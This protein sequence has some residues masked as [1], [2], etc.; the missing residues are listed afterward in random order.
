[1]FCDDGQGSRDFE[2]Q[3]RVFHTKYR[4]HH[5][6]HDL[7][8]FTCEHTK[9]TLRELNM[10]RAHNSRRMEMNSSSVFL[11]TSYSIVFFFF[12]FF[13]LVKIIEKGLRSVNMPT[14]VLNKE[15][16]TNTEA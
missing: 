1:M 13:F 12:V 6:H 16:F 3:S 11:D 5:C 9:L 10:Q 14:I 7:S 2:H 4:C 15:E 8:T